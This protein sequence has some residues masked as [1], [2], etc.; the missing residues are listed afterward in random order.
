MLRDREYFG[1]EVVVDGVM[2]LDLRYHDTEA[3][4]TVGHFMCRSTHSA[5]LLY[6]LR[7]FVELR[8]SACF[9]RFCILYA[10][11]MR[12]SLHEACPLI[13]V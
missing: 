5:L 12:S 13:L 7:C 6:L 9:I 3:W 10:V 1:V 11:L 8:L 4:N 2:A